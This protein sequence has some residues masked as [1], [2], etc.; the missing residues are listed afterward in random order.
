MA[1]IDIQH[2]FGTLKQ[3][4]IVGAF[5][6]E[7]FIDTSLINFFIYIT[8]EHHVLSDIIS[9]Y[10]NNLIE[11]VVLEFRFDVIQIH[12]HVAF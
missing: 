6:T 9:I 11:F 12:I 10:G 5:P 2:I 1:A 4:K 3:F 8:T 7:N